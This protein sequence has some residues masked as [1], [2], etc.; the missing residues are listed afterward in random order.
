MRIALFCIMA[1]RTRHIHGQRSVCFLA[2]RRKTSA[3]GTLRKQLVCETTGHRWE[4][5]GP[6]TIHVP[7][8]LI[9]MTVQE[10]E[11]RISG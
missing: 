8:E 11:S 1:E 10:I 3:N 7:W 4:G 6:L 5:R 2:E 9:Q